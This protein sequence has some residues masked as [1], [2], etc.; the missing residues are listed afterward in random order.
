MKAPEVQVP[1]VHPMYGPAVY[2]YNA[3]QWTYPYAMWYGQGGTG[4]IEQQEPTVQ[5]EPIDTHIGT[6]T[7]NTVTTGVHTDI[8]PLRE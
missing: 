4:M 2:D 3:N 1:P 5:P 7:V 8:E 6:I